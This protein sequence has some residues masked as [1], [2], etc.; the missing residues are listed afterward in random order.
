MKILHNATS[1]QY[2][3]FS[4]HGLVFRFII[5]ILYLGIFSRYEK[6]TEQYEKILEEDATNMVY[7]YCLKCINLYPTAWNIDKSINVL[8]SMFKYM[9][10]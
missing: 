2:L 5:S 7:V 6:A 8:L 9:H 3:S 1:R 10:H 4:L